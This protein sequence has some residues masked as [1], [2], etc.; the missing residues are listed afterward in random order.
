MSNNIKFAACF[1]TFMIAQLVS[2]QPSR[3]CTSHEHF[4]ES[5][6]RC[7]DISSEDVIVLGTLKVEVAKDGAQKVYLHDDA[8]GNMELVLTPSLVTAI[9]ESPADSFE[10]EGFLA[11]GELVVKNLRPIE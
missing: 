2:A 10:V 5:V 1:M 8:K 11:N 4:V 6:E 7:I 3:S 9:E